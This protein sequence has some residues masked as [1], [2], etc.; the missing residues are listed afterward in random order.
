MAE[1]KIAVWKGDFP[2][3]IRTKEEVLGHLIESTAYYS[4]TNRQNYTANFIAQ[5]ISIS[6]NLASQ[7]LNELAKEGKLVKVESRPVYFFH[8]VT[9][10][11]AYKVR[12]PTN[13]FASVE[14]LRAA[15]S[16]GQ[17]ARPDFD[18]AVGAG[19][20]LTFCVEQCRAAI[21]YPPNGLPIL[22]HGAS[23]T[24]KSFFAQ[25]MF[26]YAVNQEMVGRDKSLIVANCSEF[27]NAPE[28]VNQA[29]FG[30]RTPEGYQPGLLSQA[31]GGLLLLDE[32]HSLSPQCQEKLFQFMDS[33]RFLPV[34]E[35]K[36]WQQ[37]SVKLVFAT[38]KNP[39]EVL[40][41]TLLRRIP[42]VCCLPLLEERTIE[43]KEELI[44][45]F[46]RQ[47]S[48]QMGKEVFVSPK[49]FQALMDHVFPG[50]VRQ[51]KN[52]VRISCANAFLNCQPEQT[53]MYICP[54]HLPEDIIPS[55]T[56]DPSH[57]EEG[58]QWINP[59]SFRRD[60]L[61][62]QVVTFFDGLL[63]SYRRYTDGDCDF[64]EFL[65]GGFFHA[66]AFYDSLIFNKEY[67]NAKI[68]A[69]GKIVNAILADV[70]ARYGLEVPALFTV[71]V[72]RSIYAFSQV[73]S[74]IKGWKDRHAEEIHA[75]LKDLQAGFPREYELALELASAIRQVLGVDLAEVNTLFLLFNLCYHNLRTGTDDI[76]GIIISH[77]YATASSIAD[78]ANKLVG[79]SMFLAIDM[80]LDTS[81]GQIIS[82]LKRT[83]TRN[84]PRRNFILL[85][86]MGSLEQLHQE[87][88][89]IPNINV[90]IINNISTRL[91]VDIGFKM[92]RST[93]GIEEILKTASRGMV[94][95]YKVISNHKKKD[96][97]IFTT[98]IGAESAE[99]IIDLFKTSLPRSLDI[100]IISYDYLQLMPQVKSAE[101]FEQHEVLFTSGI[102]DPKLEGVP[103]VSLDDL[104]TG[105]GADKID[106]VLQRYLTAEEVKVFN[107]NLLKNFSLENILQ[108]LTILNAGRLLDYV[109]RAVQ[110]LQ[111]TMGKKLDGKALIGIYIHISCLVERLVTKTPLESYPEMEAF[112]QREQ[113]FIRQVRES[114]SEI[115]DYYHVEFPISEIALLHDY[116]FH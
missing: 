85:V 15:L 46:F 1:Q 25:L 68:S 112:E 76:M 60:N 34:G 98:Q 38:T 88:V 73:N 86:D 2:M 10:E 3:Y 102:V 63:A 95:S 59:D 48:R 36:N 71:A 43:E 111:K 13:L 28:R 90:G 35:N 82:A 77:G 22:L 53:S 74:T 33:G 75:C 104:V 61:V 72:S 11:R 41:R 54:Y 20:S 52:S 100:D 9:L 45:R 84:K 47:E 113:T 5:K 115:S 107:Q 108:S 49:V 93:D 19:T 62:D 8:R 24:G 87:L 106:A 114:F 6:R 79:H 56:V 58:A 109:E 21:K 32:V 110:R 39:E 55:L 23:G 40:I 29:L 103:F 42:I 116:I 16:Q 12:L 96:T 7:Y 65:Q 31:D 57:P 97:I 78:A 92:L 17:D 89:G 14:E 30:A 18:N 67:A 70:E 66:N 51:L 105:R 94:C 44:L 99:R 26:E 91:A 37:A 27:A 101:L 81:L 69:M 80:P 50:N 4:G 64:S 83:I